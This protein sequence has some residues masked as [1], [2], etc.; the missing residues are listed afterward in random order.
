MVLEMKYKTFSWILCI[1]LLFWI[2]PWIIYA[3]VTSWEKKRII[4]IKFTEDWKILS[5]SMNN[6]SL[7]E[8][9]N[10]QFNKIM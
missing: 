5:T 1:I 2:I 6:E 9:Y 7:K 10:N 3:I 4:Q 8:K